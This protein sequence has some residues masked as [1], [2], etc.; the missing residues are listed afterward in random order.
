MRTRLSLVFCGVVGCV[1]H[2]AVA[3]APLT[4][5][6]KQ[7]EPICSVRDATASSQQIECTLT[8]AAETQRYQLQINFTGG[9]DDTSAS[10]S[11]TLNGVP[12]VCDAPAKLTL[13]AED[14][15]VSLVCRFT[16]MGKPGDRYLLHTV[17]SWN[18][19]QYAGYV[20]GVLLKKDA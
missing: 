16:L 4:A 5:P 10:M 2:G 17:V 3:G 1:A 13:F 11:P 7:S 12:L 19:A 8:A 9:H 14:G 15:D 20:L 6:A 18:H